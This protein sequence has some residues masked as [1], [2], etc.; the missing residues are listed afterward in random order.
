MGAAATMGNIV[1]RAWTN[2]N[3]KEKKGVPRVER[4]W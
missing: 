1:M 4:I 2:N 3:K